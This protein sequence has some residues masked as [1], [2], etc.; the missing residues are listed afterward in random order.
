MADLLHTGSKQHRKQTTVTEG[1]RSATAVRERSERGRKKG[2][3][4]L[5]LVVGDGRSARRRLVSQALRRIGDR[6]GRRNGGP[7]RS[8]ELQ[9][10]SG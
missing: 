2:S 3:G 7:R 4:G 1:K 8:L 5:K 10:S 6:E 9:A